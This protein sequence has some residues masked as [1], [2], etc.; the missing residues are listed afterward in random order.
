[1]TKSEFRMTKPEFSMEQHEFRRS[2]SKRGM[3]ALPDVETIA[4]TL[5]QW[6]GR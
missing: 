6:P 4:L 2:Q 5:K 3:F 1:M